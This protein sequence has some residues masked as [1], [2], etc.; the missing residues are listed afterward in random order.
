MSESL[1]S[2]VTTA[3]ELAEQHPT[4][5]LPCPE[6]AAEVKGENLAKH[7]RKVHE[8]EDG[9][10]GGP[11]ELAGDD[12]KIVLVS[13]AVLLATMFGTIAIV[14]LAPAD[15]GRPLAGV[16][17]VVLLGA[18]G[19]MLGAYTGRFRAFVTV[20]ANGIRVSWLLGLANRTVAYPV[21]IRTGG[22]RRRRSSNV[23]P[24]SRDPD[25]AMPGT[26]ESAGGYIELTGANGRSVVLGAKNGPRLGA[27][28]DEA[29]FER[30][31]PRFTWDVQLYA[32]QLAQIQYVLAGSGDL[33]VRDSE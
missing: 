22:L 16:S 14:A 19:F 8:V 7:L 3:R 2:P 18:L 25:Y 17:A 4:A 26:V 20:D 31:S 29:T 1:S 5:K 15:L 21:T 24:M 11:L 13:L 12:S 23:N 33:R 9:G 27:Y 10:S 32:A 6:C 30:S 28:W